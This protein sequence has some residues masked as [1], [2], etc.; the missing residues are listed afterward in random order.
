[1]FDL[2]SLIIYLK[3]EFGKATMDLVNFTVHE[4]AISRTHSSHYTADILWLATRFRA[5]VCIAL[6]ERSGE[7]SSD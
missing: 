7:L 5:K 1:M 4:A 6:P 3:S 2:K